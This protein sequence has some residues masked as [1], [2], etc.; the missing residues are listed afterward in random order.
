MYHLS[1]MTCL[2]CV[3]FVVVVHLFLLIVS[4]SYTR[5]KSPGTELII[6]GFNKGILLK[7][8]LL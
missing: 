5:E 7:V 6:R 3:V 2:V 1:V 8:A 4:S